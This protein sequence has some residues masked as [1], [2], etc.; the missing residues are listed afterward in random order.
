M[1]IPAPD[2]GGCRLRV[3]GLKIR[4]VVGYGLLLQTSLS[5]ADGLG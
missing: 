3:D 2:A 4:Y 5:L 1:F